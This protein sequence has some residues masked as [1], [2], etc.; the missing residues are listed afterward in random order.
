MDTKTIANLAQARANHEKSL[1][2]LRKLEADFKASKAYQEWS[3]VVQADAALLD[4]ADKA[5]RAAGTAEYIAKGEK[6]LPS[7][8]VAINAS[9]TIPDEGAAIRWSITN[10]TPA[11]AL[12]KKVF[13]DAVKAGS[14]PAEL[15][16]V[17]NLI[18]VKIH[19]D[20]SE[21]LKGE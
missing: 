7:Y 21:W 17:Q 1:A 19:S 8:D 18:T 20:L 5:F 4:E 15:G 13:E 9:V 10:F 6:H 3:Q 16:T 11:L 2:E 12:R 14:I